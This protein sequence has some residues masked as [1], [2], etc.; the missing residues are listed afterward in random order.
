MPETITYEGS[1][2]GFQIAAEPVLWWLI[3]QVRL[4]VGAA[5]AA[6]P[7]G[8]GNPAPVLPSGMAS[9]PSEVNININSGADLTEFVARY[10]INPA[11]V[12]NLIFVNCGNVTVKLG[13]VMHPSKH[14]PVASLSPYTFFGGSYEAIAKHIDELLEQVSG[15]HKEKQLFGGMLKAL[16]GRP[17]VLGTLPSRDKGFSAIGTLAGSEG[18]RCFGMLAGAIMA[19]DLMKH[20]FV[21]CNEMFRQG[22]WPAVGGG[23][24]ALLREIDWASYQRSQGVP[25]ALGSGAVLLFAK[26]ELLLRDFVVQAFERNKKTSRQNKANSLILAK[27]K[28]EQNINSDIA[29]EVAAKALL[30]RKVLAHL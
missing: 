21:S 23:T 26:F 27:P 2:G 5:Q 18:S 7:V 22:G 19:L 29:L 12:F 16:K 25:T 13:G 17:S 8:D 11:R 6:A 4:K 9:P 14:Q 28:Q 30:Q 10:N 3:E 15:H 20:G 24:E 1:K